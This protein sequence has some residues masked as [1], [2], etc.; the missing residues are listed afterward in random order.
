MTDNHKAMM[1]IARAS[2]ETVDLVKGLHNIILEIHDS[3]IATQIGILAI[4][5]QL[6][7]SGQIDCVRVVDRMHQ[8][9]RT[10]T[11]REHEASAII[12][13]CDQIS[14]LRFQDAPQP[15]RKSKPRVIK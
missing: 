3:I 4:S 9:S 7:R 2:A 13:F 5:D 14:G 15:R 8:L 10:T 11:F 6:A 12:A 1:E